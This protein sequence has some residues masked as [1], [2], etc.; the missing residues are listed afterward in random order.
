MKKAIIILIAISLMFSAVWAVNKVTTV[1]LISNPVAPNDTNIVSIYIGNTERNIV[2]R[3]TQ[4]DTAADSLIMLAYTSVWE[5]SLTTKEDS[6]INIR[7]WRLDTLNVS[8]Y[9]NIQYWVP[10]GDTFTGKVIL[11]KQ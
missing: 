6:C 11:S 10:D 4:C 2:V 9:L 5:D 8:S 7:T 3:I 1:N